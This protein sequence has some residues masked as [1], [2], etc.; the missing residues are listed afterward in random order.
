LATVQALM[1][2]PSFSLKN[3]NKVRALIGAFANANPINFH[4]A[5]GS[6]YAFIAE[7]VL[8]L[9]A[10]NPQIASRLV[11]SLMNWQH[12]EPQRAEL[13]RQ[14]LQCVAAKEGLSNDVAEIVQRSLTIKSGVK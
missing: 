11:R 10:L 5:D 7:Q 2:H 6:G 3:P 9:D 4:A 8:A 1:Q 14:A 12:Y 13:M